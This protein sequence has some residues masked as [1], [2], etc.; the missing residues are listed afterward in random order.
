MQ[1]P[2]AERQIVIETVNHPDGRVS[3]SV[4]DSGPGIADGME[5][6]I[7]EPF[8]TTK[9]HGMGMGLSIARSIVE[10]HAGE[11]SAQRL[12]PKG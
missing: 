11:I 1:E 3:I 4:S 6:K 2:I 8:A 10:A 7:F 9:P 5:R 12:V